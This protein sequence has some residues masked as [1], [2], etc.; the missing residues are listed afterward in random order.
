MPGQR[1]FW[2]IEERLK[3]LSAEGDSLEKLG[4]TVDFELFRPVLTEA[5]GG[6]DP[7]KGGRPGFD[8]VRCNRRTIWC[9]T[10]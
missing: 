5:L 1:G 8:P 10:G 7:L 4:A 6:S 2:D 3:E 9:G